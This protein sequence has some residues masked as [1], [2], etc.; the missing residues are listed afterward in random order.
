M[1]FLGFIKTGKFI[2][3]GMKFIVRKFYM[4]FVFI[5]KTNNKEHRHIS[6]INSSLFI[7]S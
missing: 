4:K 2:A 7:L 6:E 1:N 5:E 3:S